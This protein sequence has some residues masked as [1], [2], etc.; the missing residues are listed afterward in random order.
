MPGTSAPIPGAMI[1]TGRVDGAM[2]MV[3]RDGAVMTTSSSL[4]QSRFHPGHTGSVAGQDHILD[5]SVVPPVY[6]NMMSR[7]IV[8]SVAPFAA[9]TPSQYNPKS[10]KSGRS[11]VQ[12]EHKRRGCGC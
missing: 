4:Y 12:L 11:F 5:A 2:N 10:H 6:P 3:D 8:E 7:D 9:K 1:D